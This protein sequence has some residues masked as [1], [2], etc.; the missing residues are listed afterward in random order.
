[1][2]KLQSIAFMKSAAERE[3]HNIKEVQVYLPLPLLQVRIKNIK[4]KYSICPF[5]VKASSYIRVLGSI[6]W[7][8]L[9]LMKGSEYNANISINRN[10]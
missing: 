1:M 2:T 9:V 10:R 3:N 4:H 6:P 8:V 5:S 7:Q